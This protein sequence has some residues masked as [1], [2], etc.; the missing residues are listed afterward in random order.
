MSYEL[1]WAMPLK[2]N[3][4]LES[5]INAFEPFRKHRP[6]KQIF[7]YRAK[8]IH[9]NYVLMHV[10]YQTPS[11]ATSVLFTFHQENVD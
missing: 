10:Q 5:A 11:L 7:M 9:W 4:R 1:T 3:L 8:I 6:L 2:K